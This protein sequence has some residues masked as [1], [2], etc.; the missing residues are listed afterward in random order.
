MGTSNMHSLKIDEFRRRFE[1]A[2]KKFV[3]KR[4]R[5][6]KNVKT[7]TVGFFADLD[8]KARRGTSGFEPEKR[9]FACESEYV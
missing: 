2:A 5:D 8:V 9:F 6:G 7:S 3:R 4:R 1:S